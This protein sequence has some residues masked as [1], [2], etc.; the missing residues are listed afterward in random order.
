MGF[1]LL[2]LDVILF[3][4]DAGLDRL[5]VGHSFGTGGTAAFNF[6]GAGI[7]SSALVELLSRAL[8]D[9]FG[10]C[11]LCLSTFDDVDSMS[12]TSSFTCS[13]GSETTACLFISGS[14]CS[15]SS[16]T[17]ALDPR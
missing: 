15:T 7:D 11:L 5:R 3:S 4:C 9:W 8:V 17:G 13:S 1:S 16:S 2:Q 6:K 14:K 10:N 12:D